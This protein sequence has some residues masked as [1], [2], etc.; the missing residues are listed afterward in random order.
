M[1]VEEDHQNVPNAGTQKR[2]CSMKENDSHR[3]NNASSS[4]MKASLMPMK[5][6]WV[7][8]EGGHRN[9]PSLTA[10][11]KQALQEQEQIYVRIVE[12][13]RLQ[14]GQIE[15]QLFLA[16]QNLAEAE[17]QLAS[18]RDHNS[19]TNYY[20]STFASLSGNE[21]VRLEN[22]LNEGENNQEKEHLNGGSVASEPVG[23]APSGM[24][25]GSFASETSKPPEMSNR[26]GDK[27]HIPTS[28]SDPMAEHEG[29]NLLAVNS[30]GVSER[31][32]TKGK[33][34]RAGQG[35]ELG[36]T[37]FKHSRKGK[38][39][40]LLVRYNAQRKKFNLCVS[41]LR[42]LCMVRKISDQ[43]IKGLR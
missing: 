27:S 17:A 20:G 43:M 29:A 33:A 42:F 23:V 8:D 21:P 18:F 22:N 24:Q 3:R 14:A 5:Q 1:E 41:H 30:N 25:H 6:A 31:A 34:S 2:E 39:M 7:E 13:R 10:R 37:K 19:L 16:R 12:E 15:A 11:L 35:A 32:R 9:E 38:P 28:F 40:H 4:V 36:A 26:H